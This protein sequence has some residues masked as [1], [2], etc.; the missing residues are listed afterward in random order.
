MTNPV[1]LRT[2]RLLLRNWREDDR[3]PFAAMN[4]DPLVMEHFP[5]LLS[6]AES[7]AGIDRQ[8]AHFEKYGW[9]FWALEIRQSGEFIGF[10]GLKHVTDDM[11][12]A[13]AVEIGWRLAWQHWG[14]GYATEAAEGALSFAF[15]TL[16]LEEVVSFTAL[17]NL[18][19]QRVMQ[20]LGM[21]SA[22]EDFDHP[23]VPAGNPLRR[24]CLYRLRREDWSRPR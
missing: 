13:P 16:R 24:H 17:T 8:L 9:G 1:E 12:F 5:A 19:S 3:E 10:V 21:R 23:Q 7:D 14:R 20:R 2:P 11:P 4:S 6:R 18:P 22:G 15:N